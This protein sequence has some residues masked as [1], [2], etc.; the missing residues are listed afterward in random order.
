MFLCSIAM[1]NYQVPKSSTGK[2][3]DSGYDS[4]WAKPSVYGIMNDEMIVFNNEQ[5]RLD[6]LLEIEI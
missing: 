6:Y 3:P 4:Y 5:I 2:T 1:G